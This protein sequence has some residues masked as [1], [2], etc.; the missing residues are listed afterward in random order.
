M[1]GGASIPSDLVDY[2][3]EQAAAEDQRQRDNWQYDQW[4]IPYIDPDDDK[5]ASKLQAALTRAEWEQ[6]KEQF[7]PVYQELVG[8]VGDP[9]LQRQ[10]VSRASNLVGRSFDTTRADMNRRNARYGTSMDETTRE[11]IDTN[12]GLSRAASTAAARNR[13]RGA[14]EDRELALMV[15]GL[16]GLGQLREDQ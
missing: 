11:S 5:Y 9:E 1:T 15:G 2:R 16:G 12:M 3:D 8:R 13:T 10:E 6:W 4:G 14:I 7:L